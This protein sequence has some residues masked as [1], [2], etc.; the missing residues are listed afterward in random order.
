MSEHEQGEQI[1]EERKPI[2]RSQLEQI[3]DCFFDFY[4]Q[5]Y[6]RA[7]VSKQDFLEE[8]WVPGI[9]LGPSLFSWVRDWRAKE[10]SR[11]E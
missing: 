11:D 5:R 6:H 1:E 2:R 7:D 4:Q 8:V 9:S 10:S 3:L